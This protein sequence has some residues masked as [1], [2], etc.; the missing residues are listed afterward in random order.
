MFRTAL[1]LFSVAFLFAAC[2]APDGSSAPCAS[3]S[4]W[5]ERAADWPTDALFLGDHPL[6]QADAIEL[7]ELDQPS[8]SERLAAALVVAELNL[9]AGATEV[10]LPVVY[11]AHAWFAN[12]HDTEGSDEEASALAEELEA[13]NLCH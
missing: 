1:C 8:P 13:V 6:D 10:D 12:T 3:A 11:A 5:S 4:D 2:A 7:L 9:S